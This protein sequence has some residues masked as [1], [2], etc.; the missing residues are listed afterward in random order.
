[1]QFHNFRP[2]STHQFQMHFLRNAIF[3]HAFEYEHD[4]VPKLRSIHAGLVV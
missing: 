2:L 4:C 1:M 3:V